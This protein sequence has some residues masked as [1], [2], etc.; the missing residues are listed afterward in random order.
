M[1]SRETLFRQSHRATSFSTSFCHLVFSSYTARAPGTNATSSHF[2]SSNSPSCH[3]QRL[4]HNI[5]WATQVS[6]FDFRQKRQVPNETHASYGKY[7]VLST[8]PRTTTFLG[9]PAHRCGQFGGNRRSNTIGQSPVS[10]SFL[11]VR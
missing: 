6:L 5:F 8:K 1:K 3:N 9:L 4:C 2:L 7:I 11:H 10:V